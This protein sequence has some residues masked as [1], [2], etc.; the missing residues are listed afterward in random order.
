[1]SEAVGSDLKKD[2]IITNIRN[3]IVENFFLVMILKWWQLMSLSWK[4]G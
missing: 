2:D 1:M 3:F 4:T